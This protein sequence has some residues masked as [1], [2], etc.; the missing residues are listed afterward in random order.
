VGE[1]LGT[2]KGADGWDPR[3]SEREIHERLVSTDGKGPPRSGKEG[4]RARE[5]RRRQD[6]PTGQREGREHACEGGGGGVGPAAWA[7]WA[8][9]SFFLFREFLMPFLFIFS[10]VFNSNSN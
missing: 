3:G 9:L 8:E 10:R 4:A 7:S 5:N 2:T 1:R 6:W